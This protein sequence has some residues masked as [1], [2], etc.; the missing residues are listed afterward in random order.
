MSH[1]VTIDDIVI[2]DIT[3]LRNCIAELAKEGI[4]ISLVENAAFRSYGRNG[5]E[6][7]YV[8]KL[9]NANY[10]IGLI[11]NKENDGYKLLFDPYGAGGIRKELGVPV[12]S[13]PIG[14][15]IEQITIGKLLQQYAVCK[16]ERDAS[17]N[18]MGVQRTKAKDGTINLTVT[19][20]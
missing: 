5:H 20:S 8:I 16:M 4:A 7:P 19:V 18:G 17:L 2:N 14:A 11:R 3:A 15:K 1:N 10:D 12:A 13:C 6:C 9:D